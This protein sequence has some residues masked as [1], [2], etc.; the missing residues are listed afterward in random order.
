MKRKH[1]LRNPLRKRQKLRGRTTTTEDPGRTTAEDPRRT[2]VN[3]GTGNVNKD[4]GIANKEMDKDMGKDIQ[5]A[6]QNTSR[7]RENGHDK[8]GGL[9]N[10]NNRS[11]VHIL[12]REPL[13]PDVWFGKA[14]KAA[15]Q[16]YCSKT[17]TTMVRHMFWF[18]LLHP[19][20]YTLY[21]FSQKTP[22]EVD[23]RIS[24]KAI[25][26]LS[27]YKLYIQE[28]TLLGLGLKFTPPSK[29]PN[30]P[31][32]L[33][34]YHAFSRQL[35][36]RWFF[37][38]FTNTLPPFKV[39][40][41][42]WNPKPKYQPLEEIIAHGKTLL[43]ESIE[44]CHHTRQN[45]LRHHLSKALRKLKSNPNIIIKP[46]DKNLGLCVLDREWYLNKGQ[47]QL[48]DATV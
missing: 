30:E 37:K 28:K 26:N 14:T 5:M 15:K 36:L 46:A 13:Y 6:N 45:R 7:T 21:V 39:P 2:N 44:T 9:R 48:S 32:L 23:Y 42:S 34:E 25:H 27:S 43:L 20:G 35:C 40:N 4:T 16:F 29:F 47:R 24:N 12:E 38:D 31:E 19:K 10:G 11:V 1:L 18:P 17:K 3:K 8:N 33:Q 22:R 41:P